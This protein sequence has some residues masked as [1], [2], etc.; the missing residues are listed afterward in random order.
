MQFYLSIPPEKKIFDVKNIIE[1][2]LLRKAF[3]QTELLPES[4]L[5][6][7]KCAFSDG[8][9]EVNNSWHHKIQTFVENKISDNE[10]ISESKQ[11]SHCTPLTKES[12]YYR[13]IYNSFFSKR[14][15]LIP[16]FWMPNWSNA[17]DPSARELSN[18][19]E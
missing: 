13:K 16:H 17:I 6:R 5:W 7:R 18:Y 12:Y 2:R 9:S 8:V 3:D 14:E 10:F 19:K 4:V 15:N 11:I 1:K